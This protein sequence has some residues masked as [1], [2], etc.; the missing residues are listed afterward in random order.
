MNNKIVK[1]NKDDFFNGGWIRNFF[2]LP[3]INGS[4][5]LKT[6]I[7]KLGNNY[8]YEID[9]AGYNKENVNVSYEDGYL[10]VEA[11]MSNAYSQDEENT[12]IRQERYSGSCSRSFYVGELDE[13][14]ISAKYDNGILSI[15][16]PDE[17]NNKKNKIKN[18]NIE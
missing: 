17:E 11:K 2:D 18:I 10:I 1:Y 15:S 3:A 16:F 6:N 14:K 13:N 12:Y 4:N 8:I 7:K 5:I 9:M